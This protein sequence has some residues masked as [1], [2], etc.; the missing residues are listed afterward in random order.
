MY[1]AR[2]TAGAI[3]TI[4][5][6][7]ENNDV[8]PKDVWASVISS[9]RE[10]AEADFAQQIIKTEVDAL[11]KEFAEFDGKPVL[12]QMLRDAQA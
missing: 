10:R 6:L 2:D 7:V 3:K 8:D 11:A 12:E 5:I 4:H 1:V 9:P